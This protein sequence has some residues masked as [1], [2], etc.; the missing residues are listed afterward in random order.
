MEEPL[1]HLRLVRC[2]T[3]RCEYQSP[4]DAPAA[5]HTH[6][7]SLI[8]LRGEGAQVWTML[9]M[10]RGVFWHEN[11]R[12]PVSAEMPLEELRSSERGGA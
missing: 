9:D 7:G 11:F 12:E 2:A 10:K 3:G 4:E 6:D 5:L 8:C 1:Y